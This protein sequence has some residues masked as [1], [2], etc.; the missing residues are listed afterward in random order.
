MTEEN[1]ILQLKEKRFLPVYLFYGTETRLLQAR[2]KQTVRQVVGKNP[3]AFS[4][5]RLEGEQATIDAICNSAITLPVFSAMRLTQVIDPPIESYS[6]EELSRLVNLFGE[7]PPE[8][9]LL[10]TFISPAFSGKP[11]AKFKTLL[12]GVQGAGGGVLLFAEQ[13]KSVIAKTLVARAQRM[14]ASIPTKTAYFLIDRCGKDLTTLIKEVDKLSAYAL[15]REIT[16]ED[17][18]HLTVATLESGTFDLSR[19]ILQGNSKRA[20]VILQELFEQQIEPLLILGAL[21]SSFIDLYRA[22][23]AQMAGQG[24][25]A[26]TGY[27][28][29]R[30]REFRMNNALRDASRFS[31]AQ[32]RECIRILSDTDKVF[33][34]TGFSERV[35]LEMT[36]AKML[37]AG[38]LL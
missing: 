13:T 1:L 6:K 29:Y 30:G 28:P 8:N 22:K 18:C 32:L 31:Y 38:D 12:Q 21:N 16:Q 37:E 17:I 24:S 20:F 26:I 4:Y 9:L 34:S 23:C 11:S 35:L 27:Y 19:A 5:S 7:L 10:F 36:V 14:G 15:G 3:T 25:D 33:K 2:T